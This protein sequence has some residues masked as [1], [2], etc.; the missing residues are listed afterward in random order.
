MEVEYK[1]VEHV[2]NEEEK[3]GEERG[4]EWKLWWEI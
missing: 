3:E 2:D 4:G 1:Y